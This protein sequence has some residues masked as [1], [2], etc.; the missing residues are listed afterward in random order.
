[1]IRRLLVLPLFLL[2]WLGSSL[3]MAQ[4]E[5]LFRKIK[6]GMS[7]E[8]VRQIESRA[9]DISG[10][11]LEPVTKDSVMEDLFLNYTSNKLYGSPLTEVYYKF[12]YDPSQPLPVYD[13]QLIKAIVKVSMPALG[14]SNSAMAYG[15]FKEMLISQYGPPNELYE[16]E[17]HLLV[18]A[19]SNKKIILWPGAMTSADSS[20]AQVVLSFGHPQSTAETS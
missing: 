17:P 3:T 13:G 6:L 10:G 15:R 1:M 4:D 18:W 5:F 8:E 14:E 12:W 16:D 9:D 2:I 7:V 19:L 11:E 20:T